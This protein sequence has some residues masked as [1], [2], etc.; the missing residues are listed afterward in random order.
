[1]AHDP[2][3]PY[4][5]E[6]ERDVLSMA[7][8]KGAFLDEAINVLDESH[9]SSAE[10]RWIWSFLRSHW[11]A[12]RELPT[13]A[14]WRKNLEE[15]WPNGHREQAT[16]VLVNLMKRIPQAPAGSLAVIREYAQVAAGRQHLGQAVDAFDKGNL[17]DLKEA[18]AK[19]AEAMEAAESRVLGI[20]PA[21]ALDDE[22]LAALQEGDS[23]YRFP[24]PFGTFNE[25]TGGGLRLHKVALTVSPT[26][27][28]KSNV[29]AAN[30]IAALEG[31]DKSVVL[32]CTSE[33]DCEEVQARY[34]AN[35]TGLTR[36]E[37]FQTTDSEQ[38]A[39]M[40]SRLARVK[41]M[42]DRLYVQN[43]AGEPVTVVRTLA[44]QVRKK[45]PDAPILI[46]VDTP[47]DLNPPGGATKGSRYDEQT[48][49]YVYLANLAMDK[50]LGPVAIH[51]SCH[52]DPATARAKKKN[53][54]AE[55]VSDS[56]K[57]A[58]KA[59]FIV[60]ITEGAEVKGQR[61][62]MLS[63]T[64]TKNKLGRIKMFR[65]YVAADT[66]LCQYTELEGYAMGDD[67]GKAQDNDGGED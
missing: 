10:H 33:D 62:R 24:F 52:I 9:F 30:G 58:Q 48:K 51:E 59:H 64:V 34:D 23:V 56:L 49:V 6:I 36:D 61:K 31:D 19:G 41:Q 38:A 42:R 53:P 2:N 5:I 67:D 25:I 40:R 57:K 28:G 7:A 15:R 63:M 43:V 46:I 14:L 18:M 26:N 12:F 35:W 37:W 45:H 16:Q 11:E 21:S 32:H 60:H 50:A 29:E 54:K 20:L 47:D 4:D 27:V 65:V 55:S 1:M 17:K 44:L 3:L 8:K 13:G 66:S 22:R 39:E